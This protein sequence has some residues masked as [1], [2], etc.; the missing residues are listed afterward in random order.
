[1]SVGVIASSDLDFCLLLSLS[2]TVHL[3]QG[4]SEVLER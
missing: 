2:V 1:M 4:S 3:R